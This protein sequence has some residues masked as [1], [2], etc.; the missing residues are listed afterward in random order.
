MRFDFNNEKSTEFGAFGFSGVFS[1]ENEI[2]IQNIETDSFEKTQ[3]KRLLEIQFF[4]TNFLD[5]KVFF[6]S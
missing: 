6:L 1:M 3:Q 4:F 2:V 5:K